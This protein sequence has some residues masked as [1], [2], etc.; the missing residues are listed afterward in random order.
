MAR[1]IIEGK[2]VY[3]LDGEGLK[4]PVEYVSE[5]DQQRDKF[6]DDLIDDAE[7]LQGYVDLWEKNL[8]GVV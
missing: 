3:W 2:H 5:E 8:R 7:R 6:V 4:V 1:I